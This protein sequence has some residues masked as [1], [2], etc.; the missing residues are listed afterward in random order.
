MFVRASL[1]WTWRSR[2]PTSLI[3]RHLLSNLHSD[4]HDNL[5]PIGLPTDKPRP[6]RWW[7]PLRKLFGEEL[8]APVCLHPQRVHSQAVR[9]TSLPAEPQCLS[10]QNVEHRVTKPH[11]PGTWKSN[12]TTAVSLTTLRQ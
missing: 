1:N 10:H 2:T 9:I 3:S 8:A 6:L 4:L 5:T 7:P 11:L 12:S